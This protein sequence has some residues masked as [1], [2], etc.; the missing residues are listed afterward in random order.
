MICDV[1]YANADITLRDAVATSLT[2]KGALLSFNTWK[3][4]IVKKPC[5]TAP[6]IQHLLDDNN[7]T[8]EN[9]KEI[10]THPQAV[11]NKYGDRLTD[12]EMIDD[13]QYTLFRNNLPTVLKFSPENKTSSYI[14]NVSRF[15]F[16]VIE[17]AIFHNKIKKEFAQKLRK[18]V[19]YLAR[20][21][22]DDD[23]PEYV[24]F[25]ER[26]LQAYTLYNEIFIGARGG[27]YVLDEN[28]KKKYIGK[29]ICT[30]FLNLE[31]E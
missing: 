29:E 26:Y 2:W 22:E 16:D 20:F 1:F 17:I 8:F 12:L 15:I 4:Y 6:F 21:F 18:F 14:L 11:L 27:V 28:N 24:Y 10:Y 5:A 13:I 23:V 3:D 30:A 31:E 19:R 7:R 9:V 25:M